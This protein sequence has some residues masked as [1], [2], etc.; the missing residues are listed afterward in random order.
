MWNENDTMLNIMNENKIFTEKYPLVCPVCNTSST[1]LYLHRFE[2]DDSMGAAWV[3]CSQ[4]KSY[5]H[6][7][8]RIP[9]SW[10]NLSTLDEDMLESTPDYLEQFADRIDNHINTMISIK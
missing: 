4:C 8:F 3:W 5:V 6:T 2:P 1:H 9:S 7:Q 10:I